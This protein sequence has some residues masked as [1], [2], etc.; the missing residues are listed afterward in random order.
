MV[1]VDGDG[2]AEGADDAHQSPSVE[3]NERVDVREAL[4]ELTNQLDRLD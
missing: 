1:G 2:E 3:I 4:L